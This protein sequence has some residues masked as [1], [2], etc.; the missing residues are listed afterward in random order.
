[1]TA[2]LGQG[3]ALAMVV[4]LGAHALAVDEV[5]KDTIPA[6][7]APEVK[8]LIDKLS[9]LDVAKR[10]EGAAELGKMGVKAAPA[11]LFLLHLFEDDS[12]FF[13]ASSDDACIAAAGALGTIGRPAVEPVL[14]ALRRSTGK[15]RVH[16]MFAMSEMDDRRVASA[17]LS[18]LDD[19][20][21]A[22]RDC[23]AEWVVPMLSRSPRFRKLPG[24][25]GALVHAL[26]SKE[27]HIRSC[28]AIALGKTRDRAAFEPLVKMLKDQN[29]RVRLDAIEALTDLGD[30]RAKAVLREMAGNAAERVRECEREGG[31]AAKALGRFGS[32]EQTIQF[33]LAAARSGEVS[34]VRYNAIAV[35]GELKDQRA[36]K[37]LSELLESTP[38]QPSSVRTAA[39]KTIVLIQG[40]K[41][42][43]LLKLSALNLW[44]WEW[45]VRCTAAVLLVEVTNGEIDDLDIVK[46]IA[47]DDRTGDEARNALRAIVQHGATSGVRSA[48]Q[49]A[50]DSWKRK[51]RR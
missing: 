27:P 29:A 22:V 17:L 1:M 25:I 26:D 44:D 13:D 9:S 41:A 37:P 15:Q 43:P 50:L 36:V 51:P 21:E 12:P 18:L 32:D 46:V 45:S 47:N 42:V 2:R 40:R 24:V 38:R 39:L 14:A 31:A 33:L 5:K 4:A 23:A 28:V 20:D 7:V 16:F 34:E 19:R 6:A 30:P 10:A 8:A 35:L 11:I 49:S 3:L 48:A